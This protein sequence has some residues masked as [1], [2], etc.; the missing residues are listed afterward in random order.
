MPVKFNATRKEFECIR[1]IALRYIE[2]VYETFPSSVRKQAIQPTMMDITA[3]HLNGCPLDL[4]RMASG[5]N[6]DLLHDVCGINEHLDRRTG[7]LKDCF[8]PRFAK[9]EG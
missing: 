3:C 4:E 5:T 9:R 6:F 1:R 8:L 7:K 2:T